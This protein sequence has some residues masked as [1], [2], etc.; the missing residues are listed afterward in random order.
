M[1]G[2]QK[3]YSTITQL[4]TVVHLLA[5]SLDSNGQVDVIFL[6]FSKAFDKVPH[7]K[8]II[9]L[10]ILG[11][12]EHFVRWI[13][14]Y[15]TN[16]KQYTDIGGQLSES[17]PVTSGVPQGSVLGPLLFLVYIN[18]IVNVV[19]PGVRIRMFAD[20]CVL[21]KEIFHPEDQIELNSNLSNIFQWCEKWEMVLN[22]DKTVFRP[23]MRKKT[24]LPFT[25]R[26]GSSP[27]RQVD[28]YKYLGVTITTTLSWNTHVNSICSS[29]FRK[30]CFLKQ[31]SRRTK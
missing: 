16:K 9:K 21:F 6:D 18:D 31:T 29:A 15:L 24:P 23:I 3:G 27:L 26:F 12:P 1:H 4:I 13:S 17:L 22:A 20:D 28:S 14:A 7:D 10:R 30:L 2:F 11:I 19:T 8:L 25:Y 5:S